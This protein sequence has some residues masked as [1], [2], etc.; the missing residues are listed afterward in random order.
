M[1]N[2]MCTAFKS[3]SLLLIGWRVPS[4]V[5]GISD[6]LTLD[7]CLCFPVVLLHFITHPPD[8]TIQKTARI[9]DIS[10]PGG[11]LHGRQQFGSRQIDLAMD[12]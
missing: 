3:F 11:A 10:R 4:E 8:T 12:N 7:A 9:E 6:L 2:Q 5:H 1:C